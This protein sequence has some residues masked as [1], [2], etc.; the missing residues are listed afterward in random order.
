MSRVL[1]LIETDYFEWIYNIICNDKY[2]KRVSY[3]K[4]LKHLHD[5]EFT[6][7]L[8]MDGNRAEDG[9]DLRYKF[10]CEYR[11]SRKNTILNY[12]QDGPCTVLEM[13]VALAMRCEDQIMDNP[14]MGN[15]TGQW[16]WNMIVNLGLGSMSDSKFDED[17]TDE[18]ID[19]LLNREYKANGEGGLFTVNNCRY[20]LRDVEIW[21]QMC[22]YL[23]DI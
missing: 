13:M 9:R 17:Y 11:S 15:R 19:R 23:D 1:E 2:S 8:D 12:L 7:I 22:W 21:Y 5:R 4:L 14:D 3:R 6:Y 10:A 20:D 18:V 16:F